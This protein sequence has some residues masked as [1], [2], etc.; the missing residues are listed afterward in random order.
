MSNTIEGGSGA[1]ALLTRS[2]AVATR[3]LRRGGMS[4]KSG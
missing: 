4:V 2:V 1:S 3:A